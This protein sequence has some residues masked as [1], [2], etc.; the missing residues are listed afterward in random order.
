MKQEDISAVLEPQEQIVWQGIVNRK[1]MFFN[2]IIFLLI[3]L[4]ISFL[5]FSKETI[6]YTSNGVAQ[7]VAGSTVGMI[8]LIPGLFF[9]LLGFFSNL[10][11]VYVIT[12][13]RVLIK[14]GIIGTD[15]NSIY[16]TQIR[17]ANVNVGLLDKIFGVGT[18]NIDTGKIETVQSGSGANRRTGTRTAYDKLIHID[19]PYEVYKYFQTTLTNRE[20]SLYSGRADRESTSNI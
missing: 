14:S 5:L 2:L 12:N 10:V 3:V 6:N 17:T 7:A 8:V 13:K 16:F 9:S 1:V 11:K 18:I 15:F 4:G 20:E 19:T